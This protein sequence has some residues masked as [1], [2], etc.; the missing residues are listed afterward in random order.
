VSVLPP[1][2]RFLDAEREVVWRY[3]VSVVGRADAD[4][5]FQETFMAALRAYPDLSRKRDHN[6]RAWVLT[7][8]HRKAM[9][10]FNATRRRATPTDALPDVPSYDA[11]LPDHELWE[12]VHALPPKMRTAV[13]LRYAGD[14]T[15]AEIAQAMGT[16]E[17]AA[18]RNTFEGLKRLRAVVAR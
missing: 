3:A 6:L 2:Q 17:D 15:H 5:V 1:F 7:I 10:H 4:D 13:T 16:S 9:D 11:E 12:R 14:L 18:R 8:A